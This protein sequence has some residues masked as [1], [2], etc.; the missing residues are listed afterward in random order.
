MSACPNCGARFIGEGLVPGFNNSVL[1]RDEN[2]DILAAAVPG[3]NDLPTPIMRPGT[4]LFYAGFVNGQA[5]TEASVHKEYNHGAI[6]RPKNDKSGLVLPQIRPHAHFAPVSAAAGNVKL[7]FEFYIHFGP[8][9][10]S[11]TISAVQAVGGVAWQEQR[12]E[13]GAIEFPE[14]LQD[15]SGIQISGRFY[16]DPQD[17]ADT[18]ADDIVITDSAGW[19]YPVD[20]DGSIGIFSKYG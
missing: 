10:I 14:A 18:Y 2:F 9:S 19:H 3:N 7:F 13:I 4:G 20:S 11:G 16:R 15:Q 6:T 1:W 8:D 12:L 5:I 17:A